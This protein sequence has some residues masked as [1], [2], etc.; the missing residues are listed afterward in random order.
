MCNSK[1]VCMCIC[2]S[3]YMIYVCNKVC[4]L[5]VCVAYLYKSTSTDNVI[6]KVFCYYC[7]YYSDAI[8]L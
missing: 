4:Y 6:L 8:K 5:Y 1:H 3:G 7:C 2:L